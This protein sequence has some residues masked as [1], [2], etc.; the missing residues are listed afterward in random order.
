MYVFVRSLTINKAGAFLATIVFT[1]NG[2]L[3]M[4]STGQWSTMVVFQLMLDSGIDFRISRV[5][6]L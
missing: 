4:I 3:M 2:F 5:M 1:F 6:I